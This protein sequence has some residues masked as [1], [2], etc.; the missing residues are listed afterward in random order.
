MGTAYLASMIKNS[1]AIN[2]TIAGNDYVNRVAGGVAGGRLISNNFAFDDMDITPV[3]YYVN[4]ELTYEVYNGID[5]TITQLQTLETYSDT[6]ENGGLGWKFGNDND[7][8][9]KWDINKNNGFPY[10]YWQE[11]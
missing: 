10:L 1:A 6:I 8:P 3:G 11:L 5:K 2:P 7:N 4:E 9:W